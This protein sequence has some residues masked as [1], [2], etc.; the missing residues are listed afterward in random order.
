[1]KYALLALALLASSAH[2]DNIY[3][4]KMWGGTPDQSSD[5]GIMMVANVTPA[6][7]GWDIRILAFDNT[8]SVAS[9]VINSTTSRTLATCKATQ[10]CQALY[11]KADMKAVDDNPLLVTVTNAKGLKFVYPTRLSRP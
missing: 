2:A 11:K 6:K 5:R 3:G 9:I 4:G 1:M 7:D 8:S 10:F